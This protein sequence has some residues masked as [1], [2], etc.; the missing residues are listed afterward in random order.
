MKSYQEILLVDDELSVIRALKR[1]LRPYF[2]VIHSANSGAE[3][4]DII[5]NNPIQLVVSDYRMPG[6]DGAELVIAIR[7]QFPNIMCVILSGQA[8]L[9]GISRALNRGGLFR[10]IEKP[11]DLDA[12]LDTLHEC[13]NE[14][15]RRYGNDVITGAQSLSSLNHRLLEIVHQSHAVSRVPYTLVCINIADLGEYNL[16]HGYLYGNRLL[17]QVGCRIAELFSNDDL[18]RDRT[19]FYLLRPLCK[20]LYETLKALNQVLDV[21]S[22]KNCFYT[23]NVYVMDAHH[24]DGV[25]KSDFISL[26]NSQI[27]RLNGQPKLFLISSH[28]LGS[29]VESDVFRL[30]SVLDGLDCGEFSAF[31]QPQQN[32]I[33]GEIVSFEALARWHNANERWQAPGHFLP[34]MEK[35]QIVE[36]LTLKILG[37]IAALVKRFS[38]QFIDRHISINVPGGL[39]SDGTFYQQLS[40][41]DAWSV[42]IYPKLQ[43][44]ITERD[45]ISDF[46]AAKRQI[47]KL[48]SLGVTCSLDDFGTGYAGFEYLCEIQFDEVKIDG[49]FIREIGKSSTNDLVLQFMLSSALSLGVTVVAE[50]V[51]TQEQFDVLKQAG[52]TLIQGHIV[53]QALSENELVEYLIQSR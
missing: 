40:E 27:V 1:E 30:F 17:N 52:C 22:T 51:E 45:L 5:A 2:A 7:R 47:N 35:Y 25:I 13:L 50:W 19:S 46:D 18:Y 53:S 12:L 6:M 37:E 10:F 23:A 14:V 15:D 31:Y 44:E 26:L 20:E 32:M 24:I 29:D 36:M 34:I 4:L 43:V 41:H 16:S 39:L 42:D 38:N 3:A 49:R 21:D 33:S 9:E 28:Q 48:K 11:W 8:D